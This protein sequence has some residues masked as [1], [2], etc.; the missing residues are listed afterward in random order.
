MNKKITTTQLNRANKDIWQSLKIAID[1]KNWALLEK[2]LTRLHSLQAYY[3]ERLNLSEIEIRGLQGDLNAE[4][5]MRH[6]FEKEWLEQVAK[7][8]GT[9]EAMKDRINEIWG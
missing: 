3:L 1:T 6:S 9:Y 4:A 8:A 5:S 2:N 7:R